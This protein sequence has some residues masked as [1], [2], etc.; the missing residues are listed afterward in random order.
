MSV[1]SWCRCEAKRNRGDH[2]QAS[3]ELQKHL[4][5]L[6]SLVGICKDNPIDI[7]VDWE[8]TPL[9]EAADDEAETK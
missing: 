2:C 8:P 4:P 5:K 6:S 3:A 1:Q 9:Y 7:G